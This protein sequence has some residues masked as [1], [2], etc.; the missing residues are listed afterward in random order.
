LEVHRQ[1]HLGVQVEE[2]LTEVVMLEVVEFVVKVIM[3][4]LI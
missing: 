2:V 4:L 3:E 1:E